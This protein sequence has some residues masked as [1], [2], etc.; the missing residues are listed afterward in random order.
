MSIID[1]P[2]SY[3]SPALGSGIWTEA[4]RFERMD[5]MR[6]EP[7]FRQVRIYPEQHCEFQFWFNATQ[8]ASFE[9]FWWQGLNAGMNQIRMPVYRPFFPNTLQVYDLVI[10]VDTYKVTY[11]QIMQASQVTIPALFYPPPVALSAALLHS[12]E[13]SEPDPYNVASGNW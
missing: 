6:G 7:R 2:T 5:K 9:L 12:P 11:S 13:T 3:G 10:W 1:W 8:L 4:T